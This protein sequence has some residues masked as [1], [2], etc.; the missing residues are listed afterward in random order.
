MLKGASKRENDKK[1]T[2][3]IRVEVVGEGGEW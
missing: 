3:Q 1:E 2:K